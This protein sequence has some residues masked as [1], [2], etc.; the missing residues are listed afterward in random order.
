MLLG[1]GREKKRE[2]TDR[3]FFRCPSTV[4]GVKMHRA[5]VLYLKGEVKNKG[6]E[7]NTQQ[8]ELPTDR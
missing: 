8:Q 5:S 2:G 4:L 7:K 1:R 6:K 3:H